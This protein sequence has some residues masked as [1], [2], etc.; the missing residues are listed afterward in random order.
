IRPSSGCSKPAIS[1]S[2]V[3]LPEPEGPSSVK[4]SPARTSRS[5]PATA[6]TS[7]YALRTPVSLTS[8][9]ASPDAAGGSA[10]AFACVGKRLLEHVAAAVELLVDRHQRDEDPDDI[11]VQAAREQDEPAL[12]CVRDGRARELGRGLLRPAVANQLE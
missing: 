4:N 10:A 12:T 1:R 9:A 5:T 8:T 3:V 2:V 6:C 11:P 7:P